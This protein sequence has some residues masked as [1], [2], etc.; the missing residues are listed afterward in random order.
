MMLPKM[1]IWPA[2]ILSA[3]NSPAWSTLIMGS[4][5]FLDVSEA[6]V[7]ANRTPNLLSRNIF[8]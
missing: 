1:A 6:D 5:N 8:L 4:N 7:L 2:Y 3:P